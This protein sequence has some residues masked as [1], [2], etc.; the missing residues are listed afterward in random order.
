MRFILDQQVKHGIEI[1]DMRQ[2]LAENQARAESDMA[3]IRQTLA[4]TT[5][6]QLEQARILVRIEEGHRQ[7]TSAQQATEQAL[8]ELA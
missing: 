8:K 2:R 4:E 7:R 6:V 5:K 3:A 1:A